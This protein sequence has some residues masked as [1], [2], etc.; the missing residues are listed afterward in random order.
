MTTIFRA[1]TAALLLALLPLGAAAEDG[2]ELWL[3]YPLLAEP[4]RTHLQGRARVIVTQASS[5]SV[6]AAVAELQRGVKGMAGRVPDVSTRVAPGAL[7]LLT[8]SQAPAG[9]DVPW[10]E[11]GREGWLL[12]STR[13]Q[14]RDVTVIA[15]NSDIGLLYGSFAWLRTAQTG[16]DLSK[17]DQ[18]STPK[19]GLRLLNHWDN[20]DRHVERGY[21]G[22]S[23]WDWWKLPDILDP[24]YVDYARA[25]A[26]IGI[27]GTVLNNVNAKSD[28]LTAPFLAKAAAL[29]DVFRPYGV[30]VYLSARFSAPRDLG[31]LRTSDPLDPAVRAWWKAKV[32]EIYKS[33]PDFGGFLV[34][35][36]SEGQ[37]GP[38]DYGRNHADGANMMAEA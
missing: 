34:K 24:R 12:R 10:R 36:N 17:V 30:K 6:L 14:G 25:N 4:A 3:R 5:P 27:N 33:I 19:V 31:G 20:L 9:L 11:L 22:A 28:S 32:D 18:R 26:S 37:P 1:L 29:A 15:A 35:A 21:S 7:V 23:L 38:Q 2:H 16:A 13:L 8:P